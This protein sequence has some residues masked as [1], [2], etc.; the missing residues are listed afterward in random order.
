[1][2]KPLRLD[3]VAALLARYALTLVGFVMAPLPRRHKVTMLTRQSSQP[4]S[5]FTM[6]ADAI[7]ERDPLADVVM[8]ARMVPP[9]IIAK[10]RY[11]L[12]LVKEMYHVETSR[13][14]VVDGY[15]MVVSAA[16]RTDGLTV[17]QMWHALGALK[18]FGLSIL[19]R[20][21][22]RDPRLARA[23]RM[24]QG[25]DMVITSAERG[26]A[27]FAEALG[28]TRDKVVVAPLPRVDRLRDP[29]E[30]A[31]ARAVFDGLYPELVGEKIA[32]FAPTFRVG[33]TPQDEQAL[34]VTEALAGAGYATVTKLHPLVPVP[35]HTSLRV[36][37]GL[38]TQQMLL[39]ADVFVTDYSS[40]VFEAAVVGVPSYLYAPDRD[41]YVESRDF[42]M[43]Y[44]DDLG[45]TMAMTAAELTE[46][47]ASGACT[48]ADIAATAANHVVIPEF[49][50]AAATLAAVI[51]GRRP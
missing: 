46:Q 45:L 27:A 3:V 48:P 16:R 44:P 19:G 30:R 25:Y 47:V 21:G 51:T 42:Y 11:A 26:R 4:S 36:A 2:T 28:V 40:A 13:V 29:E 49:G 50:T 37:P 12:H 10:V 8:I 22:G 35:S 9:G 7:R 14:V 41:L 43:A 17:V 31:K 23:M 6:L 39:V 1:M 38:S 20:A 18:K 33:N 24:H 5:D 34:E 15:S 32:L